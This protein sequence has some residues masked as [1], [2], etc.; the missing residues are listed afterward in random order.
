MKQKFF[1]TH[2]D[3]TGLIIRL[4]IGIVMFAHGARAGLVWWLWLYP[5]FG[6]FATDGTPM[7]CGVISYFNRVL[8]THFHNNRLCL[9]FLGDRNGG[10][11]Y[12][13]NFIGRTS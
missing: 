3:Y 1:S 5:N 7:A 4:T 2:N 11:F 9:P 6:G 8:C 12:R 13:D 10:P